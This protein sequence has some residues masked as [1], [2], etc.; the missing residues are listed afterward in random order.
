[1]VLRGGL[2]NSEG[3]GSW[4]VE[5][6]LQLLLL[7]LLPAICTWPLSSAGETWGEPGLRYPA[8][9]CVEAVVYIAGPVLFF[10]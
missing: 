1:M 9:V 3:P 8:V 10:T 2:G 4:D 5:L 7:L 6:E